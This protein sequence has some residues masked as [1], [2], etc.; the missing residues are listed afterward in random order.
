MR[1]LGIDFGGET[2]NN[3]ENIT[4]VEV[5]PQTG[6]PV[7][8]TER[9]SKVKPFTKNRSTQPAEEGT[10]IRQ[11]GTPTLTRAAKLP[12]WLSQDPHN[13]DTDHTVISELTN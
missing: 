13:K 6:F 10:W 11:K 12:K 5:D 8:V 2:S 9:G 1:I 4:K 7:G 3:Q